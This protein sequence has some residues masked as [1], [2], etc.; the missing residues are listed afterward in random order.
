MTKRAKIAF[1][2][3]AVVACICIGIIAATFITEGATTDK[4]MTEATY[5]GQSYAANESAPDDLN[6]ENAE[7]GTAG[8]TTV[9]GADSDGETT[10]Y[11]AGD[12]SGVYIEPDEE[13]TSESKTEL[14]SEEAENDAVVKM[15]DE[16]PGI[17]FES[18]KGAS[19]TAEKIVT[20]SGNDV[21][22]QVWGDDST[23]TYNSFTTIDTVKDAS[24]KLGTISIPS[25]SLNVGVYESDEGEMEDMTM[26]LAHFSSTSGWDGN[27]G[28]CGHNWTESGYGA[29]LANASKI[30]K[31][32]KITYT[33]SL[34]ERTYT[35]STIT[36]ISADDWS[37]LDRTDDNRLTI[38]T[39]TFTDSSKRLCI[40]AVA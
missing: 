1:I 25:I 2:A 5:S 29:Y 31:G 16:A 20:R 7:Y 26:G 19:G 34:G 12:Y 32:D 8:G 4:G 11:A 38:I 35:V 40:Q 3:G 18:T 23:T 10:E 6:F 24:G 21:S 17:E 28:V 30:K 22:E 14:T 36:E 27:V 39:C 13:E 15:L 33:T 9:I 37:Y